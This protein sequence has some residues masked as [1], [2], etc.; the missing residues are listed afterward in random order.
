MLSIQR[1]FPLSVLS[2]VLFSH[3]SSSSDAGLNLDFLQGTNFVPEILK[4][5]SAYPAGEYY[6]DVIVNQEST[7]KARLTISQKDDNAGELCFSSEWLKSAGVSIRLD[8]YADT[9]DASR[10][11]YVL[12]KNPYTRVDFNYSSQSLAFSIPQ[13]SLISKTDPE[14]WDYGVNA[15]RLRYS[16]NFARTTGQSTTAFANTDLMLNL[17]RWVLSSNMNASKGS[18]GS[19]E[20]SA[21]DITLSTPLSEVKGDLLLGKSQT[22]SELFSDFG[23][24]GAALRSN[25]NMTPWESRGYAP[26]ITGVATTTSRITITQNGYTVY[27]RVVPPGPYELDD[28]RPVGN[29]DMEVT[30]EDSAGQKNT[31]I[32]PVTTLPSLLRP[33]ELQYNIAVGRKNRSSDLKEAFSSDDGGMFWLG[34]LGYGFSDTTV[35]AASVLH[36]K[37]RAGGLSLTQ[38]LGKFGAFSVGGN[39]SKAKY[40]NGVE[41]RGHS[42]S[43]KY[44]KS[45]SASTDLQLLAYR[46][47]SK[48][49]T[50]FADFD[51]T[52]RYSRYNKK[53]RYEM[54]FSQRLGGVNLSLSGWR[55]NY[56][57]LKNDASGGDISVSSTLFNHVSVF[58]RGSY[59]RQPYLDKA[60]Y[61]TSLS[62]SVPFTIGSTRHYSNTN[63]SYNR[64]T[65]MG[66]TAG[67]SAS[68]TGRMSY[69][70]NTTL[71]EKGDSSLSGNVSYGFDAIQTSVMFSQ[72]RD[73][74]TVS[75]S[76]SG[77]VL[78]SPESGVLFTRE[79]G[80]TLG[81]VHLPDV[82]GVSF[83][84]SAPTNSGGYTVVNLSSYTLNRINVDMDNVPDNVEL[85]TTSYNVVPTEKA[86]VYRQFAAEHV[87]R[88]IM[89][90]KDANDKVFDG[91]SAR[92]EQG[93]NA[94]FVANNGVLL[95]NMLSPPETVTVSGSDGNT[96]RFSMNGIQPNTNKVQEVRCE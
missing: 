38:S 70:L 18:T 7:G 49:Y 5:D 94:G 24:Y 32:Y 40:D 89:R 36:D 30:V 29:G 31:T 28:V 60:D 42:V 25:S 63:M 37:Y 4:S 58:L 82:V 77:T 23:F 14:R 48:G 27:S 74:T 93:L 26:L 51:A 92:T 54:R 66:M 43:A 87:L 85:E 76:M 78:G 90:V 22:R 8:N 75:G 20:F 84:G 33:G 79:T 69:G 56:W 9:Q 34:S 3:Y 10:Q 83:N 41:K 11:C 61:S 65:G 15:A 86:V 91:G 19:T 50:E 72:G 80:N 53:A 64:N 71:S 57:W 17:G 52:D 67:V 73:Q 81:V 45:F 88:Y 21:R 96:C 6:V 1:F 62:F 12:A 95:M 13:T 2:L 44:A 46:Y 55:E 39:L 59:S 16:G 68:P 47:Q 35:N